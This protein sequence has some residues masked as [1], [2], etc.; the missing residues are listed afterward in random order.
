MLFRLF[1]HAKNDCPD[2]IGVTFQEIVDLNK[3]TTYVSQNTKKAREWKKAIENVLHDTKNN[4]RYYIVSSI[5]NVGVFTIVLAKLS[6]AHSIHNVALGKNN[7]T[8][9]MG[10]KGGCAI[11]MDYVSINEKTKVKQ[12]RSIVFVGCHLAAK[13]GEDEKRNKDMNIILDK[14]LWRTEKQI[15]S[16]HSDSI[17]EEIRT[18]KKT[19]KM[20][21]SP[22]FQFTSTLY[23][24][25]TG[26][27]GGGRPG[28]ESDLQRSGSIYSN[29]RRPSNIKSKGGLHAN[30]T[31]RQ[32]NRR[33][34]RK[35]KTIQS[36]VN[37]SPSVS[38]TASN[39]SNDVTSLPND[40]QYTEP[41]QQDEEEERIS[42]LEH[43]IVLVFGDLNYRM[44]N[45]EST[46]V[47]EMI[48]NNQLKDL[49]INYE[50]LKKNMKLGKVL[51]DFVESELKFPPTY[52]FKTN[53]NNY[54]VDRVPSWTDRILYKV[55]GSISQVE[56]I[57]YEDV[58]H[59]IQSD[60]KP[61]YAQYIF[62]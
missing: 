22:S 58:P 1:R 23:S 5:H 55:T 15:I 41:D 61:V 60:H 2:I 11:R 7:A 62:Y 27:E 9:V 49:L 21:N 42:L 6:L 59:F 52:K 25:S 28:K 26:G 50:H 36:R 45:V 10:N 51:N 8:T 14:L 38:E 3:P 29:L 48:E 39:G 37:V 33:A 31:G 30:M 54:V 16:T 19:R 47:I 34:S 17:M 20:R 43:D 32:R 56:H 13:P 44:E 12:N 4:S 46:R 57:K 40:F 24:T 18:K 35:T 53:T